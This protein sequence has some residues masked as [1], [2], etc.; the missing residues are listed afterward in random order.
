MVL[1]EVSSS[2][3]NTIQ[4]LNAEYWIFYSS[5]DPKTNQLWC[6]VSNDIINDLWFYTLWHL[7][8]LPSCWRYGKKRL[9]W[10]AAAVCGDHI[11]WPESGV[12]FLDNRTSYSV[13]FGADR[14]KDKSNAF[15]GDPWNVHS[16]PTI[17]RVKDVSAL[18]QPA[19]TPFHQK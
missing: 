5:I 14:W 13:I 19:I 10:A 15:R 1:Q 7:Q 16:V 6:P 11:R 17:I 3:V 12:C 2:D 4:N 9:W 18:S 8:G